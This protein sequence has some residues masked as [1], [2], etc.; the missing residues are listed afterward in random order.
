MQLKR[1]SEFG[2]KCYKT[3]YR[4]NLQMSVISQMFVSGKHFQ[5]R[6]LFLSKARAYLSEAPFM[7]STLAQA[8]GRTHKHQTKLEMSARDKH[9]GIL[10]TFVNYDRKK[11]YNIGPWTQRSSLLLTAVNYFQRFITSAKKCFLL[12]LHVKFIFILRSQLQNFLQL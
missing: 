11:V 3:F 1:F 6:L 4:R 5:D 12:S 9:S 2:P 7:C 8:P 10:R